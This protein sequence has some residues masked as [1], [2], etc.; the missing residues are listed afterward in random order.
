[1]TPYS[2][3]EGHQILYIKKKNYLHLQGRRVNQARRKH[4]LS[5]SSAYFLAL[6]MEAV[7]SS[8]TPSELLP[9]YKSLQFRKHYAEESVKEEYEGTGSTSY[10]FYREFCFLTERT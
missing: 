3:V 1:M 9:D 2:L 5:A 10:K 7:D 6:K 8:E 4:S